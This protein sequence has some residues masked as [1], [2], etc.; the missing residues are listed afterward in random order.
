M[1]TQ[2][3]LTSVDLPQGCNSDLLTKQ[4]CDELGVK[5]CLACFLTGG[6]VDAVHVTRQDGGEFSSGDE[7]KI[8]AVAAQHDPE[9]LTTGQWVETEARTILDGIIDRCQNPLI[10]TVLKMDE[11]EIMTW[12]DGQIEE[13]IKTNY[14][15][16]YNAFKKAFHA[17]ALLKDAV[18]YL[19]IAQ[20]RAEEE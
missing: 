14:P 19:I 18:L 20:L 13:V 11:D 17:L 9:E 5:I 6:V 10:K 16:T 1:T 4:L 2:V 12:L 7:T 3:T 8:Y 15:G